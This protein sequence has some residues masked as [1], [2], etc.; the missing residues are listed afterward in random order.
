MNKFVFKLVVWV[1]M[2]AVLVCSSAVLDS[3][4]MQNIELESFKTGGV[5]RRA[6]LTQKQSD[7]PEQFRWLLS[8]KNAN[9]SLPLFKLRGLS[10]KIDGAEDYQLQIQS[11]AC[12][13]DQVN[14]SLTSSSAINI[15]NSNMNISGIG[16]D[17]F[18]REDDVVISIRQSVEIK[19]NRPWLEKIKDIK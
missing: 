3:V 19:F 9:V 14:R 4:P 7:L 16:Y 1:L 10:L 18:L 17:I 12:V 5:L 15:T 8:G 13:F 6:E 2:N 11:P